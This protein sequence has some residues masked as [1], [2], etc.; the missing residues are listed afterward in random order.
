VLPLLSQI[1]TVRAYR[2]KLKQSWKYVYLSSQL[3][4]TKSNIVFND[5][6]TVGALIAEMGVVRNNVKSV[7]HQ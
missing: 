1:M 4:T 6:T 3:A 2:R 7:A 5:T